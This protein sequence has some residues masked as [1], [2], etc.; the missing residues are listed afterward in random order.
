MHIRLSS[1]ERSDMSVCKNIMDVSILDVN[2]KG[3]SLSIGGMDVLEFFFPCPHACIWRRF[4]D[5]GELKKRVWVIYA[6]ETEPLILLRMVSRDSG[7]ERSI[8]FGEPLLAFRQ[9]VLRANGLP[10][11]WDEP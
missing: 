10:A 9:A 7:L 8:E 6:P 3:P 2:S 1:F 11:A 4:S 5:E